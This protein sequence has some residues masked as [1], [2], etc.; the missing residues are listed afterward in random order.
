MT[1]FKSDKLD[2]DDE[3]SPWESYL[4]SVESERRATEDARKA[5]DGGEGSIL[6]IFSKG[7][8]QSSRNNDAL[9]AVSQEIS[10]QFGGRNMPGN[11]TY[12]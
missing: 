3:K 7:R 6:D 12:L 11:R 8:E 10:H 2:F 9:A 1:E 4:D 5:G